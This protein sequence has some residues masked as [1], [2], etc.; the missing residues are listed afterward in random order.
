MCAFFA[1][2]LLIGVG[3]VAYPSV[4]DWWNR[5]HASYVIAGYVQETEDMSEAKKQDLLEKARAYNEKL[6]ESAKNNSDRWTLTD[7]EL[8]EYNETLDVSGTGIMGYVSIPKL[9]VQLPVYHTVDDGVLQIAAGHLPGSS[10]PIGGSSTHAV[11]SGHTG[12][13]SATLFTGLTKLVKGDTFSF[14][15]LGETYTYEVDN[16][17]TVL[18]YQL[19]GLGIVDGAD[20]ATLITC[21][22]YGVNS[23]RLLVRGHRIPTP[24]EDE[25]IVYDSPV[26]MTLITCAVIGLILLAIG[27]LIVLLLRRQKHAADTA[28]GLTEQREIARRGR[29]IAS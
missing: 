28:A 26:F 8:K 16:I 2:L 18:P 21:T 14:T 19:E 12:L 1:F 15:V 9:K 3:L 17:Q 27:I 23:H 13:P 22:P 10:L 7:E 24:T 20:V 6:A 4:A 29:H 25:H 5:M 11:V